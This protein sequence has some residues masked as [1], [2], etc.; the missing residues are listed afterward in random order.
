MRF[1]RLPSSLAAEWAWVAVL[2]PCDGLGSKARQLSRAG[3][4][5]LVTIC[6]EEPHKAA[7][8]D[9]KSDR[10]GLDLPTEDFVV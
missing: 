9:Q 4:H 6:E 3:C 10:R 7:Q 2:I 8:S 5:R 1:G